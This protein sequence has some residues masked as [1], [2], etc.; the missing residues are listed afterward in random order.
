MKKQWFALVALLLCLTLVFPALAAEGEDYTM[1]GKLLKQLWAGSGFSGTLELAVSA[2]DGAQ[3][4]WVTKQP[5]L[6]DWDYIY[7]RPAENR[8]AEH[9]ADL[10]L[11]DGEN[12]VAEAHFQFRDGALAAQ[13]PL[14]GDDWFRVTVDHLFAADQN[15]VEGNLA[16]QV[17]PAVADLLERSG[18]PALIELILPQ[19][20]SRQE[21][22]TD[23]DKVM[24]AM[25]LRMDLWFEGHRQ[26][27][28]LGK[29]DDDTTTV[30]MNYRVTPANIKAQLKQ[31]VLDVLSDNA[32]LESLSALMDPEMAALFL[33]PEL[34]PYYFEAIDALPL[35]G[36]LTLCRKVD[37]QGN[38]VLLELSLPFYD[39]K[40]GSMTLNYSRESGRGDLPATNTITLDGGE[41]SMTLTY[42][43]YSSMTDVTVYQGTF[44][45]EDRSVEGFAVQ[46]DGAVTELPSV[47]FT[48]RRQEEERV[49]DNDQ[50]VYQISLQLSLEPDPQ[51]KSAAS[52]EPLDISLEGTFTSRT[53][54]TAA[55]EADLQLTISGESRP[56]VIELRFQGETRRQWE[57]EALPDEMVDLLSLD[58]TGLEDLLAKLLVNGGEVL[59]YFVQNTQP[60]VDQTAV[61]AETAVE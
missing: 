30:E 42:L 23:V 39:A 38:T 21:Q 33:N 14:L 57:V 48:L 26:N 12:A 51:A 3:D 59:G 49:E 24:D 13:S 37:M 17:A 34:Q 41:Q 52:F 11:M 50:N 61:E 28:V 44:A 15:T 55:T 58:G 6:I 7:V 43:E 54:K 35:S 9:R 10:N 56:Q 16:A 4:V 36:D 46:P 8:L 27:A 22:S 31:M 20:L 18:M 25:S 19:L 29:L 53:L 47:A 60:A 5:V 45:V 1:A 32:M 40:G 2:A